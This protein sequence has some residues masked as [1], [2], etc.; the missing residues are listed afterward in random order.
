MELNIIRTQLGEEWQRNTHQ[1]RPLLLVLAGLK[2]SEEKKPSLDDESQPG[3]FDAKLAK[4][5]PAG[6]PELQA[7]VYIIAR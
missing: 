7:P 5:L 4:G 3:P 1:I 2:R 6:T